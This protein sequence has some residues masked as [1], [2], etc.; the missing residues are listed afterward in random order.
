MCAV[1]TAAEEGSALNAHS[2]D[3]PTSIENLHLC[4]ENAYPKMRTGD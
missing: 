2:M 4:S 3:Q 1:K